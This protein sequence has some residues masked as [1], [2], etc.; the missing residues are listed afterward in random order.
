MEPVLVAEVGSLERRSHRRDIGLVKLHGLQVGE[1]PPRFPKRGPE[2]E[3]LAISCDSLLLPTD[4][5]QHV[6][7]AHPHL[8]LLR[9]PLQHL[10]VQRHRAFEFAE[11][12]KRRRFQ[13]PVAQPFRLVR[14]H[15]VEKLERFG[16]TPHPPQYEREIC[17]C[18]RPRGCDLDR[19]TEQILRV[20]PAAYARGKFREHPD[21][22]GVEWIL[23]EVRLQDPLGHIE[24][25]FVHRDRR[26]D[27][28]RMEMRGCRGLGRHESN[29]VIASAATQSRAQSWIASS[30]RSSQ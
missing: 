30:L 26:L 17:P 21:R 15:A 4:G 13:V 14:E 19:S 8:R 20:A 10:F 7:V 24:P 6:A 11:A 5:L 22:L 12:A 18:R 23:I 3:R 2:F 29:T 25:V 1:T 9:R 27:E 28:T 16:R